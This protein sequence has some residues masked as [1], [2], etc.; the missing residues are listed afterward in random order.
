VIFIQNAKQQNFE[1]HKSME[2]K[3]LFNSKEKSKS[4]WNR[5]VLSGSCALFQQAAAAAGEATEQ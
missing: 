1:F 4:K 5:S 2:E 3:M